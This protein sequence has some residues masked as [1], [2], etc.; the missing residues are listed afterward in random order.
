MQIE[1]FGKPGACYWR[2]RN[3]GNVTGNNGKFDDASHALRQAQAHVVATLKPFRT[4]LRIAD[5]VIFTP[6]KWDEK[7]KCFVVKWT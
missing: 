2:T 7:R 1:I 6:P 4:R 3:K 5:R